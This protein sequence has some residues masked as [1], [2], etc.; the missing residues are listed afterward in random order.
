MFNKKVTILIALITLQIASISASASITS[1]TMKG[2]VTSAL[3][4]SYEYMQ[5]KAAKAQTWLRHR[6][7]AFKGKSVVVNEHP[8]ELVSAQKQ[9][10]TETKPTLK[11]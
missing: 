11:K 4:S 8:E 10:T 6:I 1:Q 9:K 2:K 3:Q 5:E 7:N